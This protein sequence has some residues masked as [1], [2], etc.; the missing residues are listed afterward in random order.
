MTLPTSEEIKKAL[1]EDLSNFYL[2][3]HKA[4]QKGKAR[5]MEIY[6]K[7]IVRCCKEL[8]Y[9]PETYRY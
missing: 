4:Q 6:W 3:Y 5:R 1:E 7:E 9:D 2:C 8:G